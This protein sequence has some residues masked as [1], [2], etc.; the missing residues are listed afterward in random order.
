VA[1]HDR[2]A[3]ERIDDANVVYV[4]PVCARGGLDR[5]LDCSGASVS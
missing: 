1:L 4:V 3:S 5:V 2:L